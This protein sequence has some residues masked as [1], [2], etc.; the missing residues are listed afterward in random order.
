LHAIQLTNDQFVISC[1]NVTT[2]MYDVVEVDAK[3]SAIF[4]FTNQLQSTTHHRFNSPRRLSVD[5]NNGFILEADMSN[6]RIVILNRSLK[7]ARELNVMSVGLERPSCLYFDSSKHRLFVGERGKH[8]VL[9]FDNV[10]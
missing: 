7:F 6:D 10:I 3:G 4:S 2:D 9:I 5:K 8:R 1:V